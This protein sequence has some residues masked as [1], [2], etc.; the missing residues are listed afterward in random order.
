MSI[1]VSGHLYRKKLVKD[2][3][4]NIIDWFDEANGGWIIRKG[5]VVNQVRLDEEAKHQEDKRM[6]AQAQAN[7]V[8]SPNAPDRIAAPSKVEALEKRVE[9]M[10]GT[11][12]KIL[13]AV[14]K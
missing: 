2:L 6:A 9:S 5:Q 13:K 3:Q 8:E 4:G 12:E 11:L 1:N 7:P 14:S 10:E